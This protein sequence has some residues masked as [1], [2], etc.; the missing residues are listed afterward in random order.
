[1]FVLGWLCTQLELMPYY[2]RARGAK[3]YELT[4]PELFL[5]LY[6]VCVILTLIPRKVRIWIKALLYIILYGV[7]LVDMFCY[8]RFESTLT[9]TMLMLVA[10]TSTQEA[11]EFFSGYLSW[12][13]VTTSVGWILLLIAVHILWTFIRCWLNKVRQRM[14][15][16]KVNDGVVVGLRAVMGCVVVWCLYSSIS[17]TWDN[18]VAMRRLFS[19]NTLGE[20]EREQNRKD[21]AK[22]YLPVYRLVFGIYANSL[23]DQHRIPAPSTRL[24]GR[25]REPASSANR[26]PSAYKSLLLM[27]ITYVSFARSAFFL[28]KL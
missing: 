10:E 6:V 25:R 22:L 20:V 3:P 21:H 14:I 23:A 8:V 5:D 28:K 9:P 1:M 11:R 26:L 13:I 24:N 16:P 4:V 27:Q 7:A 19:C 17:Q 12:D 18:K 15:L 2:L